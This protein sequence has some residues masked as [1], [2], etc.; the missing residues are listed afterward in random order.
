LESGPSNEVAQVVTS[1]SAFGEGLLPTSYALFQNYPNPFNAGTVVSYQLP[2][3]SDVKLVVY[4]LL[5]REV[6]VLVNGIDDPGYK[7]IRFDPS[8]LSSG[9]YLYRLQARPTQ[10]G[11][12]RD[13]VSVRKLLLLK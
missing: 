1:S 3:V 6:A 7:S 13:F 8:R 5:G 11:E 9:V 10:R 12:A 4:D 2:V